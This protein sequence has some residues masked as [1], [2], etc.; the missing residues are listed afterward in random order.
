MVVMD[1]LSYIIAPLRGGINSRGRF[2]KYDF[3]NVIVDH[4][5]LF[6]NGY[7]TAGLLENVNASWAK[8]TE[9]KNNP[10]DRGLTVANANFLPKSKTHPTVEQSNLDK[11]ILSGIWP[12]IAG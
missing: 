12:E 9:E 11:E 10:G 5:P 4:F 1:S 7:V 6:F 3:I 8:D 2:E